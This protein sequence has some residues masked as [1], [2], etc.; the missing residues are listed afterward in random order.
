M[1]QVGHYLPKVMLGLIMSVSLVLAGCASNGTGSGMLAGSGT[2]PDPR[3]T[4]SADAS[5][6]LDLWPDC[7]CRWRRGG[8]FGV[9]GF[10][11]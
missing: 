3:L 8:N 9:C 4:K 6:F 10:E 11:P 7:L 1:K 5:F 2:A